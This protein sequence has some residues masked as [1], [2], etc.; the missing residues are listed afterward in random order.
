MFLGGGLLSFFSY[1]ITRNISYRLDTIPCP[2]PLIDALV[3][4]QEKEREH[5]EDNPALAPLSP[6]PAAWVATLPMPGPYEY[7]RPVLKKS[8]S[9]NGK[10]HKHSKKVA[11]SNG[12]G[13][14]LSHITQDIG[15]HTPGE[16]MDTSDTYADLHARS[17][18]QGSSSAHMLYVNGTPPFE[19]PIDATSTDPP[20]DYPGA[21]SPPYHGEDDPHWSDSNSAHAGLATGILRE[22]VPQLSSLNPGRT[23]Y[24][25]TPDES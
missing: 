9:T 22:S 1:Q 18:T 19:E 12:Q 6:V 21:H 14:P 8:R 15:P 17:R 23:I 20:V 2:I 13:H 25:Q 24:S 11:T 10:E 5:L 3:L 4:R 7:D 16:Q